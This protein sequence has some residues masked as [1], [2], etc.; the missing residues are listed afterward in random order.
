M[1]TV[2]PEPI[3]RSGLWGFMAAKFLF[4]ANEIGLFEALATGPT[5][6][7]ELAKRTAAPSRTVGVAD[8]MGSFPCG[9]TR[10]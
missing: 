9:E 1:S 6:L 2:A 8:A 5:T 10:S 3:M 7:D 4:V